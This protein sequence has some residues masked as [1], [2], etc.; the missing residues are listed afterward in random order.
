MRLLVDMPVSPRTA[1]FLRILG[2]EVVHIAELDMAQ[3]SDSEIIERAKAEGMTIVTEDLDYGTILAA[4]GELEPGV[5][6]LRVGNWTR[7]QIEHRL[8]QVFRQMPEN[9]FRNAIAVMERHRVRLR[10]L[11]VRPES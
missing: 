3:A 4:T 8:E 5:I 1:E 9:S 6:I 11:P 7:K 2:H 10:R